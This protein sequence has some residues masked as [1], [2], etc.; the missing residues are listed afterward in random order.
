MGRKDNGVGGWIWYN[1][2]G[3]YKLFCIFDVYLI[4]VNI[5]N[6]NIIF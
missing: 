5:K 3:C 2:W 6:V 1:V 4:Y